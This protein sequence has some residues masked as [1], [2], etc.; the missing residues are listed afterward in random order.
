MCENTIEGVFLEINVMTYDG[1]KKFVLY[2]SFIVVGTKRLKTV[3][4]G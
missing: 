1:R 3:I 2:T 4:C